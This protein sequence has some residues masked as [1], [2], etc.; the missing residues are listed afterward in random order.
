MAVSRSRDTEIMR[1]HFE[2]SRSQDIE[3]NAF[4]VVRCGPHG[5][6][7]KESITWK[8]RITKGV[9]KMEIPNTNLPYLVS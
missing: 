8:Y 9:D 2:I 1:P 4:A 3:L 6:L 5:L 7:Q